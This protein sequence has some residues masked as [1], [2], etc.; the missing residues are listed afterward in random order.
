VSP[1]ITAASLKTY[2]AKDL[3]QMAKK[4]G[5]TGWHSMRKDALIR[6]ILRKHT[7]AKRP[8]PGN[9][10]VPVSATRNGTA[11]SGSVHR[12]FAGG[13]EK[14]SKI[15]GHAASHAGSKTEKRAPAKNVAKNGA[16]TASPASANRNGAVVGRG[17]ER[18]QGSTAAKSASAK[19]ASVDK[20]SAK[21]PPPKNTK[22]TR[23]LRAEYEKRERLK[24][25]SGADQNGSDAARDRIV[26]MVRDAFWLQAYWEISR[27]AIDRARAALAEYWHTAKPVLRLL[28]VSDGGSTSS[29][30]FVAR[31]IEI[32]GGCSTWYIDVVDPP[33]TYRVEIG[34]VDQ[35]GRFFGLARSNAVTTPR[36]GSADLVDQ[37]W[38]DVARNCERIF[39]LSGGHSPETSGSGE[40]Q[41]LFE[42]RLR[43]PMGSPMVTRYGAGAESSLHRHR[44]FT[45][46][47][48][49][50]MIVFGSTQADSHVTLGGEPV[51]L[52][53]DGSFIM[54]MSLPE[55]RQVLPVVSSSS[56]GVQQQTIVL[57][58]ERNTKVM[59]PLMRDSS[60]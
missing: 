11:P 46:E 16:A 52:R 23:K 51:K 30:E 9:A 42:E 17:V 14:G 21:L 50:E 58:I 49:A 31:T 54:R 18:A 3:A 8:K 2:T 5:V 19:F 13:A 33:K 10:K 4:R 38:A 15:N 26:V 41:E 27:R 60:E 56:D 35:K 37:N 29:A 22:A 53:D 40:L 39:A 55:G 43:R 47:V 59:E 44:A 1:L 25:I 48:D 36:A 34:Y 12:G 57:A 24:D 32:H 6:A 7:K 28:E 45:F 20:G